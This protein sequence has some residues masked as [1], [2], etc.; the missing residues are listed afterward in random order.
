MVDIEREVPGKTAERIWQAPIQTACGRVICSMR[1]VR[2]RR[3]ALTSLLE[4]LNSLSM[5]HM[6]MPPAISAQPMMNRFSR[7]LPMSLVSSQAGMAV[8]TKEVNVDVSGGL[9]D[10]GSSPS[11]LGRVAKDFITGG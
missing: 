8:T 11:P 3:N 4:L 9:A 6:A 5:S 1:S 7:C 10:V 2:T